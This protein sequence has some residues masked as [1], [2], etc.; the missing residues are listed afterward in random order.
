[1][2]L[3]PICGEV[4]PDQADRCRAHD[5]PLRAWTEVDDA[6][7]AV[8]SEVG[9]DSAFADTPQ[10]GELT[11]PEVPLYAAPTPAGSVVVDPSLVVAAPRPPRILGDRYRLGAHIGIGGYGV[12]FDA[13]D[14]RLDKRVAIKILS[15]AVAEDAEILGRFKREAMAAS[16]VRHECIVDVTDFDIEPAG[17]S[18]IV[19]ELL[20]GSDLSEV[21]AAEG[22]LAPERALAIAAQCAS[23][24]AAAHRERILH[25]DLK[26]ANIFLVRSASRPD[27]VK[28]IDFGIAKITNADGDYSSVTSASKVVGTPFYMPPEQARGLPLDGRTD[29]YALGIILFEMLTGERPFTGASA[30]EILTNA[31]TRPRVAPSS[32]RP[33]LAGTPGLDELVLGAIAIDRTRR[34]ASMERFGAAILACLADISTTRVVGLPAIG[35]VDAGAGVAPRRRVR[36]SRDG[37]ER[38]DPAK[39]ST[40]ESSSGEVTG[41]RHA[42]VRRRWPL[43]LGAGAIVTAAAALW[44]VRG[45]GGDAATTGAPPPPPAAARPAPVAPAPV[46]PAPVAPAPVAPAPV[47]TPVAA[48]APA[49][50]APVRL[51]LTADAG[52]ARPAYTI[53]VTTT[54]SG[55][56]VA[57]ARG[58]ALGVTPLDVTLGS[59]ADADRLTVRYPGRVTRTVAI[60]RTRDHRLQLSLHERHARAPH[61]HPAGESSTPGLGIKDW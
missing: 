18:F 42:R 45:R 36:R 7:T 11:D 14:Q 27:F 23:G 4:Y 5:T 35:P 3:C 46:A 53:R 6:P 44:L 20:D 25:R 54:P 43:V 57:S 59:D 30:L 15:P 51:A 50:P 61:A 49:T 21:I 58:G 31:A 28:I 37:T 32:L 60:D 13:H 26:P 16:R 48:D 9:G 2:R 1:V 29:V 24:L 12:V 17:T 47:P 38:V 52:A 33:E 8:R 40:L 34:F 41:V 56:T 19:M 10:V 39:P 22:A 55:A